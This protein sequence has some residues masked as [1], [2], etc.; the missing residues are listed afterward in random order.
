MFKS[1]SVMYLL[2]CLL[3]S[4]CSYADDPKL[5]D[6]VL[7]GAAQTAVNLEGPDRITKIAD[8]ASAYA[9]FKK[10]DKA[11]QLYI[12]AGDE[13]LELPDFNEPSDLLLG[14]N[15]QRNI[16]LIDSNSD[17]G[18]TFL[19]RLLNSL[20]FSKTRYGFRDALSHLS[21]GYKDFCTDLS[22]LVWS[23]QGQ[24]EVNLQV[25][26]HLMDIRLTYLYSYREELEN[27]I[28]HPTID[29][30]KVPEE[31][32]ER[33]REVRR[34]SL[35]TVVETKKCIISGTRY[36]KN[37][38]EKHIVELV[39]AAVKQEFQ[40][41]PWNAQDIL[42]EALVSAQRLFG[43]EYDKLSDVLYKRITERQAELIKTSSQK[44]KTMARQGTPLMKNE[45]GK[46]TCEP[47]AIDDELPSGKVFNDMKDINQ[48]LA[49]CR[50]MNC[51]AQGKVS[52]PLLLNWYKEVAL[53][54][55]TNDQ[56]KA[57][58]SIVQ[59]LRDL[60][61]KD[62]AEKVLFET[63]D[64]YEAIANSSGDKNIYLPWPELWVQRLRPHAISG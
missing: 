22:S 42:R 47:E 28:D 8:V 60:G 38:L 24:N 52:V 46:W 27:E 11:L 15:I 18:K 20:F 6:Q 31:E 56:A 29:D 40:N 45:S 43:H 3:Y 2:F 36:Q 32:I 21:E 5:T 54:P 17:Y 51:K 9:F 13:T 53:A 16:L 49:L 50:Q 37:E 44:C 63:F 25:A 30:T 62:L 12:R 48:A 64:R 19:T 39:F 26:N 1:L 14:Q 59:T 10:F 55:I 7:E 61:R 57:A 23:M 35:E 41:D 33:I 58:N 4:L 34:Q